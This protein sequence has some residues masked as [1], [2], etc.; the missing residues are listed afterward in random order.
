MRVISAFAAISLG[1]A[2][3]AALTGSSHSFGHRHNHRRDQTSS[4]RWT[5]Y[6][7]LMGDGLID[8]FNF[9]EQA[10]DN[11]GCTNYV[12][13]KSSELVYIQSDGKVR[14]GADQAED[15]ALRN[16]IRMSS[17]ETFNPSQNL[18]FIVDTRC[19][20]TGSGTW[21]ETGEIDLV[22]GV[23]SYTQN[24]TSVHSDNV[25]GANLNV[26]ASE[27]GTNCDANVNH[28]SCGVSVNG[29]TSFGQV[30]NDVNGATCWNTDHGPVD[31]NYGLPTPRSW[32]TPT[33]QIDSS[34]CNTSDHFKDLMLI[35]NTNLAGLL[36]TASGEEQCCQDVTGFSDARSYVLSQGSAFG[37]SAAWVSNSIYIFMK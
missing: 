1:G 9:D 23:N 33:F 32:G 22:E 14:I 13:G 6:E 19:P 28:Q 7:S 3:Y 2:A 26:A 5:M 29:K 4:D 34:T 11:Q 10:S 12:D 37:D 20:F 24:T 16:A 21:S 27:G 36:T 35:I 15:V 17:N 30:A 25:N 31:V 18:L 8:F